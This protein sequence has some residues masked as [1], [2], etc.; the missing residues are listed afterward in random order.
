MSPSNKNLKLIVDFLNEF[1][2]TKKGDSFESTYI[3]DVVLSEKR[4]N[5][6]NSEEDSVCIV[7]VFHEDENRIFLYLICKKDEEK[8]ELFEWAHFCKYFKRQIRSS[9]I[10]KLIG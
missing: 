5:Y 9:K 8:S 6:F 4:T 2:Y 3:D 10:K 1:E 7:E